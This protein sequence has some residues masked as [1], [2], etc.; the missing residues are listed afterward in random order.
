MKVKL[1]A[2]KGG[3]FRHGGL[4]YIVPLDSALKGEDCGVLSGQQ[5][6][7]IGSLL[8]CSRQWRAISGVRIALPCGF[9]EI[10]KQAVPVATG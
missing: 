3:A 5:N 1:S 6:I 8:F 2:L 10:G 4:F 7:V 9:G